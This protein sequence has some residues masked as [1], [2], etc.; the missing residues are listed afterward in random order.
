ML[1]AKQN[2]S[3]R[4]VTIK[5]RK[6]GAIQENTFPEYTHRQY[7]SVCVTVILYKVKFSNYV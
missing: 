7:R 6:N 2:S 4:N 5:A 3:F 1:I